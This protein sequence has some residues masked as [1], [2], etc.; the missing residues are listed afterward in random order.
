MCE[1]GRESEGNVNELRYKIYCQQ[2]GKIGINMLS[3]C[4]NV[5]T[6]HVRRVNY[7][8]RIWHQCLV[9]SIGTPDGNGWCING[10]KLDVL[11]TCY[12]APDKVSPKKLMRLFNRQRS[13]VKILTQT[14]DCKQLSTNFEYTRIQ[15]LAFLCVTH[16]FFSKIT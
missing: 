1:G 5:L 8:S 3:R 12:P 13:R 6:Q 4:S 11:W 14:Q 10:D 15:C 7:Q 9:P 16:T 2:S